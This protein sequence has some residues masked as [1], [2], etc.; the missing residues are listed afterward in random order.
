MFLTFKLCA[1]LNYLKKNTSFALKSDLALNNLKR[2]I[3]HK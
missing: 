3:N 1:K 2:L